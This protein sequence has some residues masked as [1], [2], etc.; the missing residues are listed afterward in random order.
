[1]AAI[2]TFDGII[3]RIN[4]GYS[5]KN[6][7]Y[8]EQTAASVTPS[9]NLMPIHWGGLTMS[10]PALPTGVSQYFVT[11]I[12][13]L[14][15]A[16]GSFLIGRIQGMA[17]FNNATNVFTDLN[18]MPTVTEL[19][20]SRTASSP[21][22]C[23]VLGATNSNAGS[24]TVTYVDQDG[25][26]AEAAPSF[27]MPNSAPLGS[28]WWL[29]L[30]TADWG[31]RD[32]TNVT[33]SGG[34]SHAGTIGFYGLIPIA[35]MCVPATTLAMTEDLLTNEFNMVYLPGSGSM[36][37]YWLGTTAAKTGIGDITIVG[38]ST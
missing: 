27:T 33:R 26:T 16:T 10:M 2:T 14:N 9:G 1:M 15:S 20:T 19:G 13:Y 30:N 24:L 25:N 36:I 6:P 28:S 8:W 17:S 38:D 34:A 37:G 4:A 11:R 32:I 7:I 22:I 3:S 12:N 18:S 23:T 31:A 5:A 35:L 21:I 29:P